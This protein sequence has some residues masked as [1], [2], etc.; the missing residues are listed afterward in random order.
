[1]SPQS[2]GRRQ[3]P[4]GEGGVT[5]IRR[6]RRDVFNRHT[7]GCS[8]PHFA[9]LPELVKAGRILGRHGSK[10]HHSRGNG[11]SQHCATDDDASATNSQHDPSY[12]AARLVAYGR[13]RFVP[14]L[15]VNR[16]SIVKE[17]GASI[18]AATDSTQTPVSIGR[19]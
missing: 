16:S 11:A 4:D 10:K 5:K 19:L 13:A 2:P 17:E 14:D 18:A 1:D 3:S 12:G 9:P 7:D 8:G 6:S 15:L